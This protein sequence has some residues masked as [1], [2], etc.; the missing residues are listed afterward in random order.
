MINVILISME[1]LTQGMNRNAVK[2]AISRMKNGT[3]VKGNGW[4]S[5]KGVEV[6]VVKRN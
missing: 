6:L 5:S 3:K 1:G 4:D 2:V